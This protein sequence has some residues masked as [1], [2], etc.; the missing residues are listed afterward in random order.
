MRP[1]SIRAFKK[2]VTYSGRGSLYVAE[3]AH[4]YA[5]VGRRDDALALLKE[6]T[7]LA[8]KRYVSPYAFAL[9]Y[10][11]I[12]NKD[13]AFAWLHKAYEERASTLPFLNTNPTL[14]TLRSDSRFYALLQRMNLES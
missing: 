6:L 2:A 10:T 13:Q 12:G 5:V 3:L 7:E 4:A 9:V 1:E 14:A 8:R 11:G